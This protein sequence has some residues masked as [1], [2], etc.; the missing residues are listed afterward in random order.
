MNRIPSSTV[1]ELCGGVSDMSLWRWMN[2]PEKKFP[3]PIYIN[4][5]RYWREVEIIAWLEAQTDK[6]EPKHS[7]ITIFCTEFAGQYHFV[8]P[9]CGDIH[10]HGAAPG[11]R[12]SHCGYWPDGYFLKKDERLHTLAG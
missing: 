12:V 9:K 10:S 6:K 1:R 8:C 5:R 4:R 7:E 11:H 2:D 3:R